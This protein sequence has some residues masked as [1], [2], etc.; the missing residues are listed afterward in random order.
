MRDPERID[1]I[2]ELVARIWKK[3]PDFRFQQLMFILQSEYSEMHKG[4]GKVEGEEIDGFK[5]VGYDLFN[6]EDDKFLKYLKFSLEHG[7][8]SKDA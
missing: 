8:W 1:E 2:L 7:S 4:F 6:L 3:Y 5:K